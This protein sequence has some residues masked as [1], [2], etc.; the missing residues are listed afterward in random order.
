MIVYEF[1]GLPGA[2]KT[3]YCNALKHNIGFLS[4][5]EIA[6]YINSKGLLWKIKTFVKFIIKN[7]M[8]VLWLFKY[9]VR[10]WNGDFNAFKRLYDLLKSASCVWH[11]INKAKSKL[12]ILDQGMIQDI[13]AIMLYTKNDKQEYLEKIIQYIITEFKLKFIFIQTDVESSVDRITKRRGLACEFDLM[14]KGKIEN[15]FN[16]NAGN[17]GKIIYYIGSENLTVIDGKGD[18]MNNLKLIDNKINEIYVNYTR[19]WRVWSK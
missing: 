8:L 1:I 12:V 16:N 4:R 10:N 18:L 6:S 13:W 2:G 17:F 14:E 19:K 9:I 15:I 11:Y 7:Y 3:T 5:K